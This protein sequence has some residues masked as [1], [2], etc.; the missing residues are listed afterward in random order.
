[1]RLRRYIVRELKLKNGIARITILAASCM[2]TSSLQA[3]GW[4]GQKTGKITGIDL[5]EGENFGFRLYMDGTSMCGTT[6][7]W[8]FMNKSWD[9]YQ[10]T[11]A[12]LTSA[13]LTQ[14]NVTVLT[15]RDGNY[16]R[17][18]YVQFR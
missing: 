9:N 15:Y 1:M 2:L 11:A 13:Y 10:A 18:G 17:I 7:V 3:Q 12:L 8:A 14:K 5:T 4:A 6:E 16:C